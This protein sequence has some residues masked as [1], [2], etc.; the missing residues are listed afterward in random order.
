MTT[1]AHTQSTSTL[2][3]LWIH[4]TVFG[5]L[6]GGLE[7][8]LGTLLHALRIPFSGVWMAAAG[9]CILVAGLTVF[10]IRGF[11]L[12]VGVVCM[13]LKLISP[14]V[15]IVLPMISI[16]MEA[17]IVEMVMFNGKT[18]RFRAILAGTLGCLSVIVQAMTY[19]Y[20]IFGWDL[21]HI[22][23]VLLEKAVLWLGAPESWGW[24]AVALVILLICLVGAIAGSYGMTLGKAVIRLQKEE[25]D[26]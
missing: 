10:P 6:W 15:V 9:I 8:T 4:A 19:Y 1:Q 21:L 7:I 16:F 26:A 3:H 18:T 22:Y 13:L 11:A 14:G 12:R 17:A 5:A 20:F 23:L 25:A 24:I 2:S